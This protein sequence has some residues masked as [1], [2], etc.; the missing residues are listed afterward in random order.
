[1]LEVWRQDDGLIAGLT[2]Q[3]DTQV[4]RVKSD[5]GEFVIFR[6]DVLLSE[7]IEAVDG[8]PEGASIADLVPGQGGQACCRY[9]SAN[10]G[11]G[12]LE[13]DNLL[14]SAVMG[15]LTGFTRTLSR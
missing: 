4:P 3:L 10:C 6:E 14:H 11:A 8:V 1:M 15:V 2:R 5:E 13:E 12:P 7:G 9:T